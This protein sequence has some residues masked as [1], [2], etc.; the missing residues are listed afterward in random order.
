MLYK[1][2][3]RVPS[4]AVLGPAVLRVELTMAD[5]TKHGPTDLPVTLIAPTDESAT[6]PR[7]SSHRWAAPSGR[8]RM[9]W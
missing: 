6:P 3:V 2:S 1:G 8:A 7:D 4:V 5:G 9:C